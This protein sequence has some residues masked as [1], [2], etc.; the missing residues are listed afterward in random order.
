MTAPPTPV[1]PNSE[2]DRMH[3]A[4][5]DVQFLLERGCWQAALATVRTALTRTAL[6][7]NQ[8]IKR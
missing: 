2:P 3:Q 6:T 4:L 8:E 7:R 5:Q 1:L